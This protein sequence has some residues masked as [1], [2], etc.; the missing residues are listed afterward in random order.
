MSWHNFDLKMPMLVPDHGSNPMVV[1]PDG[2]I[3]FRRAVETIAR[4]FRREFHFD[5]VQYSATDRYC[6]KRDRA[7]LW[8][9]HGAVTVT[10]PLPCIGACSF[11][12]REEETG[13]ALQW[14]WLHPYC[15]RRSLLTSAW[16]MFREWFGEF[17]VE[18]P[19]S[20][21][22]EAFLA[23]MNSQPANHEPQP[24]AK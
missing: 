21:P 22:M 4:Y 12:W 15:R 1:R 6:D 2:P 23:K 24:N 17:E 7:W 16:P 20:E 10:D 18:G 14:I 13:Y 8:F 5:F 19:L 11:R 3:R 9:G